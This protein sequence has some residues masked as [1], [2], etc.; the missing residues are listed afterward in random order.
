MTRKIEKYPLFLRNINFFLLFNLRNI[1]KGGSA[2]HDFEDEDYFYTFDMSS[3]SLPT[4]SSS[5]PEK[6]TPKSV[7]HTKSH[8]ISFSEYMFHD[9]KLSN[10]PN[11]FGKNIHTE[12]GK[13]YEEEILLKLET[14]I[15][16]KKH[17]KLKKQLTRK[18]IIQIL[19]CSNSLDKNK[20]ILH[21][22]IESNDL[23]SVQL[24]LEVYKKYLD[25]IDIHK[26]DK[27]GYTPLHYAVETGNASII[28]ELLQFPNIDVNVTSCNN[29][30]PFHLFCKSFPTPSELSKI[31]DL[32][33][34]RGSN[35]NAANDSGETPLFKAMLNPTIRLLM[36][37]LLLEHGAK[38]NVTNER[39]E[40]P[41]HYAIHLKRK[42][43]V[44]TLLSEGAN[45]HLKGKE[46]AKTAYEIAKLENSVEL[47][48][49]IDKVEE[50]Q[51]WLEQIQMGKYLKNFVREKN[52]YEHDAFCFR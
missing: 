23:I 44:F 45:P 4:E 37:R 42:D 35:I 49:L 46:N 21:I 47:I 29:N 31:V 20:T 43:L 5:L 50:L 52:F 48:T 38:V 14:F 3:N 30:T 8:H 1:Q 33:L 16:E 18:N 19:N 34:I 28:M 26:K 22:A 36:V 27:D 39:G 9:R 17:S 25:K 12:K 15:V 41:L 7:I 11:L 6:P 40:T 13:N 2:E 10:S 24:L 51:I 32:F